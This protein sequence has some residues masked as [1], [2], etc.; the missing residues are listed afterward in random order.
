MQKQLMEARQ[1]LGQ[2]SLFRGLSETELSALIAQARIR[3]F[4]AGATIFLMGSPGDSLMAVLSGKVG[5]SVSTPEG[6]EIRLAIFQQGEFFGEIALFDGKERSADAVAMTACRL[7]VLERR[8]V[9]AFFNRHP[10]AWPKLVEALCSRLR[11]T[12]QHIAE[13]ALLPLPVR[14]A[15]VLSR[16]AHIEPQPAAGRPY[17]QVQL[18]Q[19]ELGKIVGASRETVNRCLRDWQRSGV[20]DVD[21]GIIAILDRS[22][23]EQ[24]SEIG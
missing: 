11:L 19:I 14:L 4:S 8:D 9:M 15:K 17:R 2:C 3:N 1:L 24:L 5:I 21:E 23:L 10:G 22:A 18:S 12:D 20:V 7:A 13:V 16:V 6:R